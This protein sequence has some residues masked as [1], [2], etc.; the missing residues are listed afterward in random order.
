MRWDHDAAEGAAMKVIAS[1]DR[2]F[3]V[4]VKRI[5]TR[6]NLQGGAVETTVRTI[7]SA[8]ARG[9]DQALVRYTKKYD[10]VTL[11]PPQ[12]RVSPEQ[13][14]EAYY[15][16]RKEE[17]DALRYA[18]QRVMAFHERQ[19]SKTWMYQDNGATLGQV[20]VPLDAVG[21]YVPGGKAVYPSSVLMCAIPEGGRG[22]AGR[23]V[24]AGFQ[25][26]DQPLPARGRRHR[27]RGRG[28][29]D[30]RR[31]GDRRHGI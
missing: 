2:A 14:K 17:G 21:L 6:S 24:H 19:R 3:K 27:R 8:V 25:G 31:A 4:M 11:K 10:K 5:T 29:P 26:R 23:D 9:G 30:R 22:E 12:F 20:V 16:I 1:T 28:V 7:L 13:V 15:Q 18:A